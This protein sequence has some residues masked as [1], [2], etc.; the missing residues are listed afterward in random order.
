MRQPLRAR[1]ARCARS[2][3]D[4]GLDMDAL[5]SYL[6][7][8]GIDITDDCG[9]E[10]VEP[11]SLPQRGAGGRHHRRAAAVPERDPPLPA[12]HGGRGGRAG[13]ADRAGRPRGQGADDQLQ[14]APGGL[15]RE[16]VPG[17]GAVAARPDPGG[18]LRADPRRREVRLAQGLQVLDL[19]DVLDPPGDPARPGQQGAHDPDPGAHRPARA[20]D[21]ARVERELQAK[22]G[23]E[24]TDE[25][26]AEAAE[27]PLAQVQEVREAAAHGHE[28]RPAG[29]RGGRHGPRRPAAR[30]TTLPWT[31]RSRSA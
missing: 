9:R 8:Q 7:A 2:S 31:R 16:E 17:P 10:G 13:Q 28:P 21:R 23:R 19:R 1:R 26:I 24:P 4:D 29:G 5:E 18:H 20:Q 6:E 22:L 12:A 14:P 15:D 30:A 11:T 25:E 27:L 3:A